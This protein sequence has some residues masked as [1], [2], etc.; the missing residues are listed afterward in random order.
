[1]YTPGDLSNDQEAGQQAALPAPS[2]GNQS[3]KHPSP[4]S[5][6]Q[7]GGSGGAEGGAAEAGAGAA[8]AGG[9][10]A[11]AGEVAELAPLALLA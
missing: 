7:F 6:K 10:G 11:A 4:L 1:M 9:I 5:A 3:Q 2:S 8:E